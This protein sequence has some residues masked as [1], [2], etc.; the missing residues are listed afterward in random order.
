MAQ[1]P[2]GGGRSGPVGRLFS[3]NKFCAASPVLPAVTLSGAGLTSQCCRCR[4]CWGVR[5][6][7]RRRVAEAP[8]LALKPL[9]NSERLSPKPDS[10]YLAPLLKV[11]LMCLGSKQHFPN[12]GLWD[13]DHLT[14]SVR[15]TRL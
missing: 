3:Y 14:I 10:L 12:G 8:A 2:G 11:Q 9:D 7:E 6:W 1:G 4:R 15:T 5:G 13:T